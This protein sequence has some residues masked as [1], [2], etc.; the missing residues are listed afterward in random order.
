MKEDRLGGLA[1]MH[2]HKQMSFS[3]EDIVDNFAASGN[4]RIFAIWIDCNKYC[5]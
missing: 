2:I 3:A 1:L 5:W 4:M